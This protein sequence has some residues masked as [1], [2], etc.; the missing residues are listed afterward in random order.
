L[1]IAEDAKLEHLNFAI[2]FTIADIFWVKKK[3]T[4]A[5]YQRIQK[6]MNINLIH[7]PFT[8]LVSFTLA[9]FSFTL[10]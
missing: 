7:P 5:C 3:K 8:P 2:L 10:G 1:L 4:N 9:K 6:I